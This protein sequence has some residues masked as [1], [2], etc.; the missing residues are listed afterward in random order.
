MKTTV[1]NVNKERVEML[2]QAL[3]SGK[4]KQTQNV[5]HQVNP[6][7]ADTVGWCCL[8]VACDIASLNGL[9]LHRHINA[10]GYES[11]DGATFGMPRSVSAW[12]GFAHRGDIDF[13]DDQYPAR[14]AAGMNDN[15]QSFASIAAEIRRVYLAS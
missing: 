5:L 12:F 9:K 10:K 6:E 13:Y 3:E 8:G 7:G 2:C 11:F 15:G 4:Y 14:T 1:S